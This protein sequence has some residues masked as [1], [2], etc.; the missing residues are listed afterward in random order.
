MNTAIRF[1]RRL[2]P[3]FAL[4]AGLSGSQTALAQTYPARMVKLV[5]PQ[6]PGSTAD[7]LARLL[8]SKLS[9]AW[10]QQVVVENRSGANG[11]IGMDYVAKSAPDGYTLGLAAPST[12]TI[13]QFVYKN[14]PF[15]PLKDLIPVTQTTAIPF[16][17]VINAKLPVKNV[18]ELVAYGKQKPNGMNFSSPGTGNLG[19]L[20]AELF[21]EQTGLTMNH[22]PSRGDT[23]GLMDVMGG[24]TDL[25]FVTLPAAAA[26]LSTGKLRLLAVC[27][28]QRDASVPD[29]PTLAEAGVP[30]VVISGWTGLVAPAGTPADI[31]N[32]ISQDV[33]RQLA[34]PELQA[35][36]AQQGSLVVTNTPQVF[37]RFIDSEAQKWSK[38][39]VATKLQ[40]D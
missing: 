24:Q 14:M 20:A 27:G 23:P 38:V 10:G 2:F 4:L 33:A 34:S 28:T 21:A 5:I 18:Q 3:L 32:K 12:L 19:H 37:A 8:A 22:I 17:L 35:S 25:M 29:V 15:Q 9:T 7:M 1:C 6:A 39:V 26:L 11:I 13:N 40:L 36:I 31:V 30:D 16:A